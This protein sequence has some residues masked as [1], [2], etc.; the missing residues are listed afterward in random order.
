MM[1]SV[2]NNNCSNKV[3]YMHNSHLIV[4]TAQTYGKRDNIQ[5]INQEQ[6]GK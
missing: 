2:L 4:T 1:N 6:Q 3:Y 5:L